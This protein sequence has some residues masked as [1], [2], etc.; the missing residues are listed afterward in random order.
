MMS[1]NKQF[2][3]PANKQ[4][5][6][7]GYKNSYFSIND[8]DNAVFHSQQPEYQIFANQELPYFVPFVQKTIGIKLTKQIH[9]QEVKQKTIQPPQHHQNFIKDLNKIFPFEQISNSDEERLIHSHGQTTTEEIYKILYSGKLERLVDLVFFPISEEDCQN[10]ISLAQ[11]HNVCLVPYGGGT[12]VS[13]ALLLP[14]NE[15]RMIVSVDTKYLNKIIFIDKENKL[16]QVQ[17][18]I[19]GLDLEKQLGKMGYTV[20]HEPDSIEFSTLGGWISTYASGMKRHKYGNIE[21][22]LVDFNLLTP[23]GLLRQNSTFDRSSIG[24][25]PKN[26][27]LGSEGNIGIITQATL[28]IHPSPKVKKYQSIIFYNDFKGI[29]FL[30]DLSQTQSLPAS[31]RMVDNLQFQFG[32]SIRTFK[33]VLLNQVIGFV[34]NFYLFKIKKIAPDKMCLATVL[35][36]GRKSEVYQQEKILKKKVSKH[37]AL[38]AG[39]SNGKRA[40]LL[41]NLIAYIRDFLADYHCIGETLE[42]TIPWNKIKPL[43][44]KVKKKV[45]EEHLKYQ[46]PGKPFCSYRITQLYHSSVCVY[47]TIGL[48]VKGIEKP[49]KVFAKIEESIRKTILKAGGSISHHHGVGKLRKK[50]M[51]EIISDTGKEAVQAIKKS[52]DKKNIFGIQNNILGN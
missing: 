40:Y 22:I 24:V 51:K 3:S 8:K 37:K 30:K 43:C 49:E 13:S 17:A 44:D 42:T 18:G 9:N 21:D 28:K 6:R 4:M 36:E 47:F 46:L 52:L 5:H 12:S 7:W 26:F 32:L 50:F 16:V 38:L 29:A 41:T 1:K 14:K 35:M 10:I 45:Q 27:V 11:K 23:T 33:K 39:A 19:V 20:G 2:S 31:V 25:Q 48:V 34:Q 15:K